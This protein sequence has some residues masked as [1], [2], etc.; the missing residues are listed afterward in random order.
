MRGR[1]LG[2]TSMRERLKLVDGEL[3]IDSEP[4]LGTIIR[5]TVPLRFA[6]KAA[7]A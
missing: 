4:G 3:S 1:G 7:Q 5:G 6:S 2:L